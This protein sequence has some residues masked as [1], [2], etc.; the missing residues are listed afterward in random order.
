MLLLVEIGDKG[1]TFLP[2]LIDVDDAAG[3]FKKLRHACNVVTNVVDE[4]RIARGRRTVPG[5][6]QSFEVLSVI[7]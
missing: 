3:G 6:F 2:F 1:Q 4:L 5:G 7:G